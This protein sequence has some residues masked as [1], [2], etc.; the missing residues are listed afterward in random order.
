MRLVSECI[1]GMADVDTV[2][3]DRTAPK[4]PHDGRRAQIGPS[5]RIQSSA[6][7]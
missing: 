2:P 5:A 1:A 3:E 7:N 4:F 6:L